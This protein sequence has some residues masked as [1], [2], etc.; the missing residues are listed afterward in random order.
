MN[1]YKAYYRGKSCEVYADTLLQAR[2]KAAVVFGVKAKKA[3]EVTVVL[4]EKDGVTVTHS[5]TEL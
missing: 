4:C 2:D 5:T 3:N 1:G